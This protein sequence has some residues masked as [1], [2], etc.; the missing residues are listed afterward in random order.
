MLFSL[1]IRLNEDT[2]DALLA[3]VCI[4]DPGK[5]RLR[6]MQHVIRVAEG[7]LE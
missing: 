1:R 3:E 4:E 6:L 5:I 7:F 2:R